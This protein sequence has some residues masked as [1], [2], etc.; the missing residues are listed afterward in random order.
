M[1]LI[2]KQI[3]FFPSLID[4]FIKEE[5]INNHHTSAHQPAVNIKDLETKFE[6]SLAVPGKKKNDFEIEVDNGLLSISTID[7]DQ[8]IKN[9]RFT[10]HEFDFSSFKRTF[11]IPDTVDSSKINAQC[12]EGVLNVNLPKHKE[13][14][15]QP[16]KL[17]KIS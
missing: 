1:N 8:N 12:S 7:K 5:I 17:I 11:N 6:I 16:K 4:G 2:T 3:P 14:Q 10:L 9:E 13:A 15:P